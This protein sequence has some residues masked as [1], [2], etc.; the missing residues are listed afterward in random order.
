MVNRMR[1]T[2]SHRNNRRAHHSLTP[3]KLV[4]CEECG[5]KKKPH[6]ACSVCGMYRGRKVVDTT[7]R[8]EK[9]LSGSDEAPSEEQEENE[10]KN[11][12]QPDET[13][14]TT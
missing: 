6:V 10:N 4:V 13:K 3:A 5:A 11:N 9:K 7:V 2:K 14:A 1:S 8:V 12:E